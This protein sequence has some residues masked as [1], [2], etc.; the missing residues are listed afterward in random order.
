M[1]PIVACP[2][3]G[4][5]NAVA[6]FGETNLGS[7]RAWC[8]ECQT[9]EHALYSATGEGVFMER[10][11]PRQGVRRTPVCRTKEWFFERTRQPRRM[12]QNRHPEPVKQGCPHDCGI[13][14]HHAGALRLPIFSITNNCNLKCPICFTHNRQDKI[15]NKSL[16]ELE[17]LLDVI[18]AE[19][20]DLDLL[21]LT[22]GEPTLHPNLDEI[23][24]RCARRSFRR[25]SMNSNGL[26][27]GKNRKLAE[28][29]KETGVQVILSLDTLKP[30]KSI[31][32]HGADIAQ[33]KANAL[34]M[35][36][37]LNIPTVLLMVWIPGINDEE[38]PALIEEWLP[39]KFIC[40]ITIQN[41]AYTGQY[42]SL[43]SPRI[44]STLEDVE[45]GLARW[46]NFA[47]GD[48]FAHG[49]YHPFC[50]SS[51]YFIIDG[52]L[53]I[54]FTS[55]ASADLLMAATEESYLL[56]PLPELERSFRARIDERWAEGAPRE[57]LAVLK[58]FI[59]RMNDE[60]ARAPGFSHE[61][62]KTVT[63]H[64]HMDEDNFDLARVSLCG[65]LVPH[66]DGRMIP[67][68]SYNL[69]YR[70]RDERFWTEGSASPPATPTGKPLNKE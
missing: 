27:L 21:N 36:E 1:E 61:M 30:D 2:P 38:L 29:L 28:K 56:K 33:G 5:Q 15:Y 12:W 3:C 34:A 6:Q 64:A 4:P 46:G 25:V 16:E 68:C 43:F 41:M 35:L 32:I 58:R 55:L 13:C 50:Y 45:Q 52:A 62:V 42:G 51:A 24:Q 23:L 18:E 69:L 26:L 20:Q 11:C 53:R 48:F 7:T 60:D 49:S 57:E 39:K 67:A 40:G 59:A 63:I 44:H 65:D 66:E 19:K 22:G 17:T 10:I 8:P 70:Q 37:E 14:A 54:P 9:V 47:A 31:R